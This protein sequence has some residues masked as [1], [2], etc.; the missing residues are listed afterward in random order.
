LKLPKFLQKLRLIAASDLVLGDKFRYLR[1]L[2]IGTLQPGVRIGDREFHLQGDISVFLRGDSTDHKVFDEIFI[3]KTYDPY[4][5]SVLEMT[6]RPFILI[7][8]GA[9]IGLSAIALARHLQPAAILAVE[10][11]PGNFLTLQENLRLA[12]LTQRCTTIQAFAGAERGFAELMDSGN[13]AWG[14]RMGARAPAGIPVIPIEDIVDIAKGSAADKTCAAMVILKC[15]IEG[16]EAHLFRHLHRWEDR[17]DYAILEL[18]TAF[19]SVENF[20]ACLEESNFQWRMDGKIPD[21]AVLA[22][23][24]LERLGRKAV[25]QTQRAAGS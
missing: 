9:N 19:L 1:D 25:V 24:G 12:G 3:Q 13:G 23:V 22:V 2:A 21:K 14:M 20:H 6:G 16:A 17:V 7:D 8:L 15:D 11:D 18:H 5:K 4:A 10:P